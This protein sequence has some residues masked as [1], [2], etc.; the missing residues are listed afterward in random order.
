M[1]V[2]YPTAAESSVWSFILYTPIVI[3]KYKGSIIP[4]LLPQIVITVGISILALY[5]SPFGDDPPTQGYTMVGFLLS[6]LMVFKTQVAYGQYWTALG[7]V[8]Q[9][10]H[11]SRCLG[12]K[13]CT[14]V[15]WDI[16]DKNVAAK[17]R[18][19]LR[20]IGV[21]WFVIM[22]YFA[23]TGTNQQITDTL[24]QDS[25]RDDI[26]HLTGPHE[27]AALYPGDDH[28]TPGSKS[29]CP[30]SNPYLVLF[31]IQQGLCTCWKE[32]AVLNAP[33]F[34]QMSATVAALHKEFCQM[35]R[36]D[37]SQFPLPY[38]QLVKLLS[39]IWVFSLPFVLVTTCG[40][41][42]PMFMALLSIG[43][44]GLDEVAEI[45]ESPF[46][47]DPN[48]LSLKAYGTNLVKDLELA[49]YAR[50]TQVDYLFSQDV[51]LSFAHLLK[52]D[53]KEE[54]FNECG[55]YFKKKSQSGEKNGSI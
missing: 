15:D 46:G 8:E 41:V 27:F 43:F 42:T 29:N 32:G 3:F 55:N 9:A 25:L 39:V 34:G 50:D 28:K 24:D 31:W 21:H 49:F 48:H 37:K 35:N 7:H 52:S 30:H 51:G 13:V 23:R 10:M 19:I 17:G 47:D 11:L 14:L 12:M 16:P 1:V 53:E 26:R 38:A 44:F 2:Q 40:N 18:R 36:I 45:L 33:S 22:E 4:N 54:D 6:F 20:L 5:W